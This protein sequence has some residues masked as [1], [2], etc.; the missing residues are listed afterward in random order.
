MDIVPPS[1]LPGANFDFCDVRNIFENAA[2]GNN[3]SNFLSIVLS[4]AARFGTRA[5]VVHGGF[6]TSGRHV[7]VRGDYAAVA[8]HKVLKL[9]RSDW[10]T[11]A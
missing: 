5:D 9:L 8:T 2:A 6:L 4:V 10:R 7:R 3:I 1:E 11:A